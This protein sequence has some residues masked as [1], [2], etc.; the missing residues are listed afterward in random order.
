MTPWVTITEANTYFV[1]KWGASAWASL[2]N[3]QKE[4]LLT[5]AYNWMKSLYNISDS[6]TD[7]KIKRA[8]YEL[9]WY[10]YNFYDEHVKHQAMNAQGVKSF[11]IMSFS[12]TLVS[13]VFPPFISDMLPDDAI[14][15]SGGKIVSVHRDLAQ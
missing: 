8:Q 6:S 1:T 2:N 9:A 15:N 5:S 11:S 3:L 10:I 7:V 4:Q 14:I 12:E 13:A